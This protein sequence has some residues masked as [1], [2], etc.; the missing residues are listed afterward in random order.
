[1]ELLIQ[2]FLFPP[3]A[4]F[5]EEAEEV[6]PTPPGKLPPPFFEACLPAAVLFPVTE[7][8]GP[9]DGAVEACDTP[10]VAGGA[11]AV[12]VNV[13]PAAARDDGVID[14]AKDAFGVMLGPPPEVVDGEA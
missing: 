7:V 3:E 1:M 10:P 13:D 11:G 12:L 8:G 9:N 4:A 5:P 2:T 14:P 6:L